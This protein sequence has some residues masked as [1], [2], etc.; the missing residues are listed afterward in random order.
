MACDR[1]QRLVERPSQMIYFVLEYSGVQSR[2]FD[3]LWFP[4]LCAVSFSQYAIC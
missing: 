1:I 3:K 4:L 2:S